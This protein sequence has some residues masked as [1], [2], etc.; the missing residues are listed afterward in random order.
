M[1]PRNIKELLAYNCLN[2]KE[3]DLIYVENDILDDY[4]SILGDNDTDKE[5][6]LY[7]SDTNGLLKNQNLITK[8]MGW[9]VFRFNNVKPY[10]YILSY[11]NGIIAVTNDKTEYNIRVEKDIIINM[12]D[13]LEDS[14]NKK[15]FEYKIPTS[16]LVELTE[17]DNDFR[18]C[19]V[20]DKN[21]IY[22]F[23]WPG[24]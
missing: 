15:Y 22:K 3:N 17:L 21:N 2:L 13:G 16:T 20:D 7:F 24:F 10:S 18:F 8:N 6:S 23:V 12:P 19:I 1:W 5:L 14:G 4:R 9:S 11:P